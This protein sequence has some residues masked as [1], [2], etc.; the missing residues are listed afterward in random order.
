MITLLYLGDL[1]KARAYATVRLPRTQKLIAR[2]SK[3][4]LNADRRKKSQNESAKA[5]GLSIQAGQRYI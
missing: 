3:F 2:Q 1:G 4:L 5:L